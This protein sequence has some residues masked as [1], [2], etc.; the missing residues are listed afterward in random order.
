MEY[1]TLKACNR[2]CEKFMMVEYM[3]WKIEL[4]R[5]KIIWKHCENFG[6]GNP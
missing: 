1:F 6:E 2:R 5:E 3:R 4:S